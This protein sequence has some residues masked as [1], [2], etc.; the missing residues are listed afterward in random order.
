MCANCTQTEERVEKS[1]R[2]AAMT[3]GIWSSGTPPTPNMLCVARLFVQPFQAPLAFTLSINPTTR[4]LL[5]AR[6]WVGH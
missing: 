2:L 5:H 4:L 6:G 1:P 3:R